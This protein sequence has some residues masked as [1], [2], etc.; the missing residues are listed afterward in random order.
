MQLVA[1]EPTKGGVP[2]PPYS[3]E[4]SVCGV[5]MKDDRA[6][7]EDFTLSEEDKKLFEQ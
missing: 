6:R 1:N 7:P 5:G 3:F 4:K 2:R